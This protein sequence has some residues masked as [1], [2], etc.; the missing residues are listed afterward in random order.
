MLF[1]REVSVFNCQ[2]KEFISA[3]K[4]YKMAH[5]INKSYVNCLT[6]NEYEENIMKKLSKWEAVLRRQNIESSNSFVKMP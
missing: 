1:V 6:E 2:I 4:F 3:R 5:Q